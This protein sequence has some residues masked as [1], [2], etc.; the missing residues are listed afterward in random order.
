MSE[1]NDD[2]QNLRD[3]RRKEFQA[4][5]DKV[6]E[7]V[8]RGVDS[9]YNPWELFESVG[10]KTQ[11]KDAKTSLAKALVR[12]LKGIPQYGVISYDDVEEIVLS[13]MEK[14]RDKYDDFG[15]GDGEA[16]YYIKDAVERVF[17]G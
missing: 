2:W 3:T 15:A 9:E 7:R 17:E 10:T 6:C 12:A 14:Y 5:I 16:G 1:H 13:R 8:M 11:L 4:R